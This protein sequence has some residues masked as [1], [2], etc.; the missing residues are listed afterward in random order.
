MSPRLLHSPGRTGTRGF[1]LVEVLVALMVMAV[2][3]VMAWQGVDGIVRSRDGSQG[4]L[5]QTMRL[6]TVVAQWEQDWAALQDTG[7]VIPAQLFD[8]ATLR[9]TRRT[10]GGVQVVAWSLRPTDAGNVWTRW[11]GP[12]VT[13]TADLQDQWLRSQQLLGNE[14]G[15][16]VTLRGLASWQLYYYRDSAWTN[17]QSSGDVQAGGLAGQ[18]RQVLPTGVRL[19][20]GFADGSGQAGALTRDIALGPQP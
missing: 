10:P 6:N 18:A 4:R 7:G 11:A 12:A 2:M 9:I 8:G 19:V 20:L 17:A 13:R 15:Q 14:A 5:E 16:L 3:A 1:T